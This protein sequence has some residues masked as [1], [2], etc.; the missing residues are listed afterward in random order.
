MAPGCL[1]RQED[2]QGAGVLDTSATLSDWIMR[3][4]SSSAGASPLQTGETAEAEAQCD[5]AAA[6]VSGDLELMASLSEWAHINEA[7]RPQ[8]G[9]AHYSP[10][11]ILPEMTAL[12]QDACMRY[13]T[14]A[15]SVML[16]P[17]RRG[18]VLHTLRALS[19]SHAGPVQRAR[20][21]ISYP[22]AL[23][24]ASMSFATSSPGK[25]GR[26]GS[27]A[28]PR[29]SASGAPH[30]ACCT[31]DTEDTADSGSPQGRLQSSADSAQR[32]PSASSPQGGLSSQ[33]WH[34]CRPAKSGGSSVSA[35][36][37]AAPAASSAP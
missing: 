2:G 37:A 16:N 36:A 30:S 28:G 14:V 6:D 35:A 33:P 17:L 27:R 34:A 24:D 20:S 29:A 19:H 10:L 9:T 5:S 13:H 1:F 11:F 3:S 25:L 7:A 21:P 23:S 32:G 26:A 22:V 18:R 8:T 4:T 31:S 12:A 15:L